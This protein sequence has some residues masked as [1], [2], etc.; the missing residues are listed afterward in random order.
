[1]FVWAVVAARTRV[2]A[3]GCPFLDAF[4]DE[5]REQLVGLLR[6]RYE[7]QQEFVRLTLALSELV[8]DCRFSTY[9]HGFT[10]L[11][12][13]L[14]RSP[15]SPLSGH[16]QGVHMQASPAREEEL[17]E[18]RRRNAAEQEAWRASKVAALVADLS[19]FPD[20]ALVGARNDEPGAPERLMVTACRR[21]LRLDDEALEDRRLAALE[22]FDREQARQAAEFAAAHPPMNALYPDLGDAVFVAQRAFETRGRSFKVGDQINVAE[23]WWPPGKLSSLLSPARPLLSPHP[24]HLEA[25]ARAVAYN[26]PAAARVTVEDDSFDPDAARRAR[27]AA[28]KR[29]QRA[30]EREQQEVTAP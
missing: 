29:A 25:C 23:F 10:L 3:A 22:A 9:A 20:A 11:V 6:R 4:G 5:L 1:M 2:G 16:F 21:L 28:R 24:D 26:N 12:G 18:S 14:R 30:A 7:P 15:R 13:K 27:D 19:A 17:D 8:E